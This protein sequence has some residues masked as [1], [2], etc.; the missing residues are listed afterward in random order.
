MSAY[1]TLYETEGAFVKVCFEVSCFCASDSQ[2][3]E[4]FTGCNKLNGF[5]G[6]GGCFLFFFVFL[7]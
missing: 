1:L 4:V 7:Y 2:F 5:S 6:L 3:P